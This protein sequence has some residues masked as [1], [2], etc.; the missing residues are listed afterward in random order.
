MIFTETYDSMKPFIYKLVKA[1]FDRLGID[2][3][4]GDSIDDE[5]LRPNILA[6]MSYAGDRHVINWALDQFEKAESPED[7]RSDVRSVIYQTAVRETND[8]LT[9][10]KLLHWYR[11]NSI[12]GEQGTLASALCSFKDPQLIQRSLET[13][14]TDEVKLQDA[15]YW[16]ANSL[17]NRHGKYIAWEWLKNHWDWIEANFAKEKE[18]DYYLRFASTGFASKKHLEDYTTFFQ[19]VDIFGSERA[20]KQGIETITWQTAWKQRDTQS[21]LQWFDSFIK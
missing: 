15:M 12:P 7:L 11:N 18:V 19:M 21:I 14:N 17:R 20:Y 4:P 2:R 16:V 8:V 9:Y 1:N 10:E 13:I 5:L 3:K 6:S